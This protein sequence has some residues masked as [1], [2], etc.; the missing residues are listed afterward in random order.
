M[1][2]A[3]FTH[4]NKDNASVDWYT[5]GLGCFSALVWTLTLTHASRQTGLNGYQPSGDIRYTMTG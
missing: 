2:A 1:K 4:D 3:G 5:P